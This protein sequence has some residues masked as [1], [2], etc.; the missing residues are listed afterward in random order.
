M[1]TFDLTLDD[2]SVGQIIGTPDGFLVGL[3]MTQGP[4]DASV[5]PSWD[6]GRRLWTSGYFVLRGSL[7]LRDLICLHPASGGSYAWDGPIGHMLVNGNLGFRGDLI[8]QS[9][10]RGSTWSITLSDVPNPRPADTTWPTWSPR[11]PA[12]SM[13]PPPREA[14]LAGR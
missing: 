9:V 10:P 4:S 1:A 13:P 11:S 7:D 8:V 3:A 5:P 12:V 14:E 6:E 2:Q